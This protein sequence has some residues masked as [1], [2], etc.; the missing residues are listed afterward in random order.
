[1]S[2]VFIPLDVATTPRCGETIV[3][4]WWVYRPSEGIALSKRASMLSPQCNGNEYVAKLVKDE[5]Y[6]NEELL[7]VPC[8]FLGHNGGKQLLT[9]QQ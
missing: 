9:S 7:F 1:M 6:P 8:V 5:L 3:D 2:L 4:H